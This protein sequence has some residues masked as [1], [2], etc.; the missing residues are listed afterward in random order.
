M[1]LSIA[2]EP[3]GITK[4]NSGFKQIMALAKTFVKASLSSDFSFKQKNRIF[5][6]HMMRILFRNL[7]KNLE[8]SLYASSKWLIKSSALRKLNKRPV[9]MKKM[10]AFMIVMWVLHCKYHVQQCGA[11]QHH[12]LK[13]FPVYNYNHW[14]HHQIHY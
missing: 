2:L 12:L 14:K 13:L 4:R 8:S 6:R 7:S 9:I 11:I 1:E 10:T 3:F 5:R